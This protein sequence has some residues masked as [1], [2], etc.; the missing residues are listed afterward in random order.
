[1][2]ALYYIAKYDMTNNI[3]STFKVYMLP[4]TSFICVVWISMTVHLAYWFTY[5]QH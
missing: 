2:H 1:M 3:W 5:Q 4:I